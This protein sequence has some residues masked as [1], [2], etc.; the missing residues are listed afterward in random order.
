[1]RRS[2]FEKFDVS[3]PAHVGRVILWHFHHLQLLHRN[4]HLYDIDADIQTEC[5]LH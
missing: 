3:F 2:V 4:V 1:M 5:Q